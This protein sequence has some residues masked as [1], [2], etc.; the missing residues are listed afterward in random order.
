VK[1]FITGLNGFVAGHLATHLAQAGHEVSGSSRTPSRFPGARIWRLGAPVDDAM[2]RGVQILIH[3][4]HDFTKGAMRV[5]VDGTLALAEAARR[6]G[7]ARQIYVSSLSARPDA[8]SEYGRSKLEIERVFLDRGDTVV[9]PGTVIGRGGVFG[10]L[11]LMIERSAVLPLVDGGR[12]TTTVIGLAD[13]CRA[14]EA[15]LGRNQPLEYNLY[16]PDRPT[17]KEVLGLLRERLGRKTLLVPVP[18]RVLL[19]PLTVLAW[20]GI[21]TPIDLENLQGYITS[22][23]PLHP[24]DLMLVVPN[25]GSLQTALAE[26]WPD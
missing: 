7:V 18:A 24:S 13:L 9:R 5:N 20:L 23:D 3:C 6:S 2:L 1:V 22:R 26:A 19:I 15:I 14:M 11:A 8:R 4:A 17:I 25:P 21:P 10:K 16:D 12:V